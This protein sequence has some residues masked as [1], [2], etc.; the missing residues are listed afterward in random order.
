LLSEDGKP[1]DALT[2]A[3]SIQT[4]APA[5]A[6]A[7]GALMLVAALESDRGES[8]SAVKAYEQVLTRQAKPF[9]ALVGLTRL[10]LAVGAIEKAATYVQQAVVLEPKN[11][12][13]RSLMVRV[14]LAQGKTDQANM[15]LG[16]LRKQFPNSPTVLDLVAAQQLSSNQ[17]DSARA[18]YLRAVSL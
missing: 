2:V 18:S 12:T 17:P 16:A 5:S 9:G 7:V 3:R 13:V 8:A 1:D 6:D 14:W 4:E 15:E 10:N 11:P